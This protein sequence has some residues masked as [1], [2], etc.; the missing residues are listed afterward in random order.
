MAGVAEAARDGLAL[1]RRQAMPA[2]NLQLV[3]KAD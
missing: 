1:A 3:F 2:N